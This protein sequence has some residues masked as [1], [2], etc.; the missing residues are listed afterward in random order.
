MKKTIFLCLVSYSITMT[1]QPVHD[2]SQYHKLTDKELAQQY[3]TKSKNQKTTGN[4]LAIA[5]SVVATAGVIF[6]ASGFSNGWDSDNQQKAESSMNTGTVL[7]VT[8]MASLVAGIPFAI[9]GKKNKKR[10]ELL[11][12]TG[13]A[14]I[15]PQLPPKKIFSVGV[16]INF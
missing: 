4:I 11:L 2:S 9:A 3:F 7:I 10:A 15:S 12:S 8:G 13:N 16:G 5:G 6:W 14:M 1:A